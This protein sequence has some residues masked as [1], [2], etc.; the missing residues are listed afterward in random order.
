[1]NITRQAGT[2]FYTID[3]PESGEITNI[4]AEVFG[5]GRPTT[6]LADT[7][8]QSAQNMEAAYMEA[9]IAQWNKTGDVDDIRYHLQQL[10]AIKDAFRTLGHSDMHL[11]SLQEKNSNA[12]VAVNQNE[13]A[14][15]VSTAEPL[16]S[17]SDSPEPPAP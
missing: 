15:A 14:A 3:T 1:M 10:L 13:P 9:I 2:E 17:A 4:D 6:L 12:Q 11:A 7:F 16:A 8:G 5:M